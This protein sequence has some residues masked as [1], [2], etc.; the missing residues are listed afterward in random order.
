ASPI[1]AS[2]LNGDS[3]TG[4]TAQY[5]SERLDEGDIVLQ[6]KTPI[7]PEDDYYSLS[8]RL[9]QL[10]A[11]CILEVLRLYE[12]NRVV[13]Q[14][15]DSARATFCHKIKKEDG[16][17]Q[18]NETYKSIVNKMKA[19]AKWPLCYAY[20]GKKK[21]IIH[22]VEW[23]GESQEG[24]PGIIVQANKQGLHVRCGDGVMAILMIQPESKKVM[25]YKSFLNGHSWKPGMLLTHVAEA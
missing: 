21:V 12:E 10:S 9:S 19:Y 13:R 20:Q 15:Q 8:D 25:D 18:F 5:M 2:L 6:L 16:A 24:E 7:E 23:L 11:D 3:E 22:K 4:I 14:P 17:I 1:Q